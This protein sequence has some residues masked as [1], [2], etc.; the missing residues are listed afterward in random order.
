MAGGDGLGKEGVPSTILLAFLRQ[1]DDRIFLR[2]TDDAERILTGAHARELLEQQ[3]PE[4][5]DPAVGVDQHL[6]RSVGDRPLADPGHDV[7]AVDEVIE[8]ASPFVAERHLV[9]R[10]LC[11]RWSGRTW[12]RLIA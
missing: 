2:G 7:A 5:I 9:H 6:A 4:Q 11:L 12:T 8:E 3:A 1:L 10:N